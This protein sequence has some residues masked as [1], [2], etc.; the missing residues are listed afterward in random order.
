MVN[1]TPK[2]ANGA[3]AQAK[4]RR[5]SSS[6][7]RKKL[8]PFNRFMQTETARLK[9]EMPELDN[10]ERFKQVIDNWNKQKEKDKA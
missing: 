3:A 4:K 6:A 8:T 10:K 1:T 9:Q 2:T 5:S 7:G